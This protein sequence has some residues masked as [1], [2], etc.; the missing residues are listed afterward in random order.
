LWPITLPGEILNPKSL[1]FKS[2]LSG[3]SLF[4]NDSNLNESASLSGF[5]VKNSAEKISVGLCGRKPRS[6]RGPVRVRGLVFARFFLLNLGKLATDGD[7]FA[8]FFLKKRRGGNSR[9]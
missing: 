8:S 5:A 2:L 9:P 1:N 6:K 4:F 3:E 7:F